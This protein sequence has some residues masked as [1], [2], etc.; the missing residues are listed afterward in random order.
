MKSETFGTIRYRSSY[1][2]SSCTDDTDSLDTLFLSVS[3]S[4]THLFDIRSYWS[5]LL[6]D[7]V[8]TIVSIQEF[9]DRA[10]LVSLSVVV[11][12]TSLIMTLLCVFSS[13]L[14]VFILLVYLWDGMSVNVQLLFCVTLRLRFLPKSTHHP[15]SFLIAFPQLGK[16]P[17]SFFSEIRFGYSQLP[18]YSSTCLFH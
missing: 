1:K 2:W 3:F 7:P 10:I 11:H 5:S 8:E 17:V 16:I 15:R 13:A 12:R 4:P 6:V 18:I 14:L 9:A